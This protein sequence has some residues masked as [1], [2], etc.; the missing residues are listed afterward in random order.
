[1]SA[2]R[3]S[4][5]RP[6]SA[7]A[8]TH[9]AWPSIT[10]TRRRSGEAMGEPTTAPPLRALFFG[11]RG[12]PEPAPLEP[13]ASGE[14]LAEFRDR[15]APHQLNAWHPRT[16]SYFT[17]PPS[18]LS[19][20][21]ELL[22]QFTQQG[23]DVWH[24][25]PAAAFVE[26]EVVRWLCDLVGY[27]EGSFG[28]LASGGVMANFMALALARDVQLRRLREPRTAAPRRGAGGRPGVCLGPGPFLRRARAGRAGVP[29]THPGDAAQRRPLPAPHGER[30]MTPWTAD[31]A[32]GLTSVRGGRG[33]RHDQHRLHRRRAGHR[34]SSPRD[35]GCGCMS[36]RHMAARR[37]L[38]E[39]LARA[40]ARPG[41]GRL[42]HRRPAQVVLPGI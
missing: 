1:M 15:V 39:D 31:L 41:D 23:V 30:W 18:V 24:A 19:I 40:G 4:P 8:K 25:G 9:G 26:E 7:W 5:G 42:G 21:G 13:T 34:A 33:V 12:G 37:R 38:S 2:T 10:C 27:G 35:T 16:L 29:G 28:L 11:E 6:W 32:A 17:P 20:V 36:T 14:L 22:A 3:P